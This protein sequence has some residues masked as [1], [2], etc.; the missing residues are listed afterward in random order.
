MTQEFLEENRI[1]VKRLYK[2]EKHDGFE[3]SNHL[4]NWYKQKLIE[5]EG[6]CKYCNTEILLIRTLIETEKLKPRAA[7]KGFRGPSLEIDRDDPDLG[8]NPTNC[9]LVCYYCNNDKSYTLDAET[10]STFFGEARHNFFQHLL[11]QE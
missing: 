6:K 2:S 1:R 8:Y 3:N 11:N 4:G 7:G 9:H 5:Q 10:Y